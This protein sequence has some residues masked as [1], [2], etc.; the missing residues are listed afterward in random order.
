ML[1][2]RV[3]RRGAERLAEAERE[4]AT[5]QDLAALPLAL[6]SD[7][8]RSGGPRTFIAKQLTQIIAVAREL[9]SECGR[10]E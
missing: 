4:G 9:P 10:P 3:G 5:N 1:S 2:D 7:G 8:P 6:L